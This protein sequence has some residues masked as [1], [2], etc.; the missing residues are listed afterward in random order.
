MFLD[1]LEQKPPTFIEIHLQGIADKN[2]FA[3][4]YFLRKPDTLSISSSTSSITMQPTLPLAFVASLL[5]IAAKAVPTGIEAKA[6]FTLEKRECD[7]GVHCWQGGGCSAE[8]AGKCPNVC[9]GSGQDEGCIQGST[10]WN[11]NGSGCFIGWSTCECTCTL[12]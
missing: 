1:F 3:I 4:I 8:W 10:S 6:P 2:R 9:K 12:F 7:S 5:V 11:I